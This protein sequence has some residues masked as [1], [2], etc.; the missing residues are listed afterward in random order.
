M[1]LINHTAC[2]HFHTFCLLQKIGCLRTATVLGL[3]LASWQ[4]I[5]STRDLQVM[6]SPRA[7][8]INGSYIITPSALILQHDII[9]ISYCNTSCRG[10]PRGCYPASYKRRRRGGRHGSSRSERHSPTKICRRHTCSRTGLSSSPER[11]SPVGLKMVIRI[12][13]TASKTTV[14]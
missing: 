10:R 7:L 13:S 11:S 6:L 9:L 3:T 5:L 4:I 1:F 8:I 12:D 14:I 2:I